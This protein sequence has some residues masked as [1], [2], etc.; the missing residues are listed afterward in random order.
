VR[1]KHDAERK[2]WQVVATHVLSEPIA[3]PLDMGMLA[4]YYVTHGTW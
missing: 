1:A 2:D 4:N 3:D